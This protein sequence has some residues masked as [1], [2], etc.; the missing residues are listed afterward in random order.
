MTMTSR[1][2]G[3]PGSSEVPHLERRAPTVRSA[4]AQSLRN[5][6]LAARSL[7]VE[8][9]NI[10]RFGRDAPRFAE[11]IWVD[12]AALTTTLGPDDYDL[13]KAASGSVL[14]GDWD[15]HAWQ[16][17]ANVV[18]ACV[19]HWRDGAPWAD[20]GAYDYVLA[21]IAR[22]PDGAFDG[23]RTLADVERRHAQMDAMFKQVA[24][25]RRLR[26]RDELPGHQFREV[27]GIRV[28][29][30]RRAN[31]IRGGD[32]AH[33]LGMALAL[34]LTVIPAMIGC[35]HA[36]AIRSWRASLAAPPR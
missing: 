11:R 35:V 17:K 31:L 33:R 2:F 18:E 22:S 36:E 25:E 32:G 26:P 6:G 30:G 19:L 4:M 29:V 14:G 8:V 24:T 15:L 13:G 16:S 27:G 1:S 7:V 9:V 5:A 20:T 34:E 12:P 21:A 10:A 23:C 28:H 3:M